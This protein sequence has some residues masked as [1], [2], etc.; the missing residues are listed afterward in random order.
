MRIKRKLNLNGKIVLYILSASIILFGLNLIYNAYKSRELA[1]ILA[2]L[3]VAVLG[4]IN[5]MLSKKIT[6][7]IVKTTEALKKVAVGIIDEKEKVDFMTDD[8]LQEMGT[9]LNLL[10]DGLKEKAD[11]ARKIGIGNLTSEFNIIGEK[12][13]L[14]NSLLEMRKS[15]L[16]AAESEKIRKSEDE[17]RNWATNG[18]AQIGEIL[19]KTEEDDDKFYFN[20]ISFIVKYLECNQGGL[21]IINDENYNDTYLELVAMYAFDKKKYLTKRIEI[22]EGL[23]GTCVL[24]RDTIYVTEIPEDYIEI[25]S[26]LGKSNPRSILIVPLKLNDSIHGVVELASFKEIEKFQIEFVEKVAESIASA[27]ST[28]KI[29]KRTK[30]LLEQSQKQTEQLRSQEEEM[31]QNLEELKA[32]QEESHRKALDMERLLREAAENENQLKSQEEEMRQNME[33][34]T[35]TQEEAHRKALEMEQLLRESEG[36]EALL[37]KQEEERI[38]NMEELKEAQEELLQK[39]KIQKEELEKLKEEYSK[40]NNELKI[41]EAKLAEQLTEMKENHEK[42]NK[43]QIE[44]KSLQDSIDTVYGRLELNMEGEIIFVNNLFLIMSE[45]SIDEVTGKKLTE[46]MPASIVES[47]EYNVFWRNIIN[48]MP[49]R[50]GHLYLFNN[51]EKYLYCTYTALK[52]TDEKFSKIIVISNDISKVKEKEIEAQELNNQLK[53]TEEELRQQMEEMTATQEELARQNVEMA[54]LF[55]SINKTVAVLEYDFNG[56]ILHV[57]RILNELSGYTTDDLLGKHHSIFFDNK[58]LD[59]SSGYKKFWDD[60]KRGN[61]FEGVMKRIAKDGHTFLVKGIC[62][63]IFDKDGKPY[64]VMELAFG[65]EENEINKN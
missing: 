21:F 36:K 37:R 63:P 12:D 23:T 64:K 18:L 55:D 58:N 27:I 43:H 24:E 33:E 50:G 5:Y 59:E 29:N 41:H 8:E 1:I 47:N 35:A 14:G 31:R 44:L 49:Q 28:V 20:I 60:M 9:A 54:G 48:G 6:K 62:N 53:A 65:I 13:V 25:T 4:I 3:G 17:K 34:L 16:E 15:L 7:P 38:R 10:V 52:D 57:N 42:I 51:K 19:R 45:L 40:Q 22:G 56:K 30:V 26:G 46:F 39:D 11:F 61:H 32:T 2:M